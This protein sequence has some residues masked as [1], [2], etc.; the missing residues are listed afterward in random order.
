MAERVAGSAPRLRA[1]SPEGLLYRIARR[2]N[3]WVWPDWAYV[4]SDG[5]FGNR[6]DDP[7]GLYRVLYASSSRLGALVE[8]LARFRPDPHVQAALEAIEGD[9]PFQA[10]G[11]LDPSWLERRCV[12][13]A[14]A[15]GSFVDVGHSR[16]L[17]ELR[18][19]L[20]SRLAQYGVAD[21]D[22][23]AIRLA[24][25][26]ALTQEISRAIYGLS[27]EAGERRFAG[28]AYRSRL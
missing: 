7:Q 20:A 18:R 26:R 3:P 12:G 15:T 22:A 23:A 24:V 6:W 19:L 11:A 27:T 9:D 16:S 25:P 4:G 13:T 21:L 2:P 10:P 28:I 5:T 14:Q 8:V 17:A 1:P